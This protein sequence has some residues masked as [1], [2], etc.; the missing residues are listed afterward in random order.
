MINIKQLIYNGVGKLYIERE[1]NKI[2]KRARN[3]ILQIPFYREK[4]KENDIDIWEVKQINTIEKLDRFLEKYGSVISP[5]P[6]DL[7]GK[8]FSQ[9]LSMV[10]PKYRIW[11][12]SSSGYTSIEKIRGRY[13]LKE[14]PKIFKRKTVAYTA[15]DIEEFFNK[16][17]YPSIKT[18]FKDIETPTIA[19][20]AHLYGMP[21]GSGLYPA[22]SIPAF[23]LKRGI[24][25]RLLCYGEPIGGR[26]ADYVIETIDK[27]DAIQTTPAI[28]HDIAKFMTENGLRY[29][30][31]E[32]ISVGGYKPSKKSVEEAHSIGA[33]IF[34]N[35]YGAQEVCPFAFIANGV[36]SSE[37]RR[38]P[39][40]DGLVVRETFV[41]VRVVD[42]YGNNVSEGEEGEIRVTAP[43][44][45]TALIDYP[46]G[47]I[48]KLISYETET[49]Y[50]SIE[51]KIPFPTLS[52]DIRRKSD[53]RTVK[54]REYSFNLDIAEEILRHYFGYDYCIVIPEV[55]ENHDNKNDRIIVLL[56][57]N[58]NDEEI[59]EI[60]DRLYDFMNP[61][62]KSLR[63]IEVERLPPN[64]LK[65]IVYP[66][67]HHK[68][69]NIIRIN[70]YEKIKKQ[71][72]R[73]LYQI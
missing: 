61:M 21:S 28:L 11:V 47:D 32:L 30:K 25:I 66:L 31:L 10:D 33:R 40:T 14:F 46:V 56:P 38:I 63:T 23:S 49:I 64:V 68:P 39:P 5:K 48:T 6:N 35:L 17:L 67:S 4:L 12:Q 58:V 70:Q 18:V 1:R 53:E 34:A 9:H 59:I 51:M 65:D 72:E 15:R 29:N 55:A 8:N 45:G 24:P 43:F 54:V 60:E 19:D 36:M 27:V 22:V 41:H 20:L 73:E 26:L 37:N 13:D 57:D 62:F 52:Y 3:A 42:K 69:H 71:L 2:A 44:E 50:N 16:I 7:M